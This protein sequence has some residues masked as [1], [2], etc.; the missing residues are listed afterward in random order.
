ML[1]VVL[2]SITILY[3]A[4]KTFT[5]D[6][7]SILF[8]LE[9]MYLL[10]SIL[11]MLL[12]HTFDNVRLFVLSRAVGIRYSFLYGYVISFINTFGAT[13]TPAHIGGE[14]ISFY[15]IMRKGGRLHKVMGVV[16]MKTLTGISFF[17]LAFPF[18]AY[19]IYQSPQDALEVLFF[20]LIAFTAFGLFYLIIR[21]VLRKDSSNSPFWTRVKYT[22]K[23]YIIT[24]KLF[25]GQNKLSLLI[26]LI[27]SIF[28]YL[29]FLSVGVFMLKAFGV[30]VSF[31]EGIITQLFL[32]YAIFLS[33]TPG[34]SGVGELGGLSVFSVYL[35]PLMLGVFV[36]LWR[37][38]SQ[39]L[40]A[41]F[42]ALM[43]IYLLLV[44]AKKH[45]K[46]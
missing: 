27:S 42:G 26:A 44:D 36:I 13:I 10:L 33:P 2:V 9:R 23:R 21:K 8:S 46:V 20:L 43:L 22:I 11:S 31:V 45:S 19:R 32:T 18:M 5:K 17:L 28:L 15:T 12:Y 1:T 14:F 3:I 38:I 29:S 6:V 4:K 39:Y 34:G 7:L 30:N 41:L 25:L 40:S 35:E 24:T 16:T 37:F